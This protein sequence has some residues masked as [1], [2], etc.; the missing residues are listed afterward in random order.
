[1]KVSNNSSAT[2]EFL[3]ARWSLTQTL[4]NKGKMTTDPSQMKVF[5]FDYISQSGKSLGN[6]VISL[7]SGDESSESMKIY[8]GK[9][10][11]NSDGKSQKEFYKFLTSLRVF[12]K[13][14]MLGFNVRDI[15]RNQLNQK[16]MKN[17]F[18]ASLN[19]DGLS[20]R[21]IMESQFGIL[22]G[23][24]MT[25]R[26][27]LD[28][29]KLIIK[30]SE[31]VNPDSRGARSRRIDKIFLA[32]DK[33]ERFLLPFKSLKGARAIARHVSTGG[34]PYDSIGEAICA[35]VDEVSCLNKFLR[36]AKTELSDPVVCAISE[37]VKT[38]VM[39]IKKLLTSLC[40]SKGY[41]NNSSRLLQK[42]IML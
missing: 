40:S 9:D 41:T 34:T 12:A 13:S 27:P 42:E 36:V 21:G 28:S 22:D 37:L 2:F 5:G 20:R 10:I 32:N 4:D 29:L 19:A 23:S 25:S 11:A 24:V 18:E 1:M 38:R 35:H 6:I 8:F 30:H 3:K 31:R 17:M 39:E 15:N 16:S 14:H 7:L 33:G 26:Q